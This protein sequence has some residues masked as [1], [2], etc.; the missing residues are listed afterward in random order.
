METEF[1]PVYFN[2]ITKTLIS[3]DKSIEEILYKI[4]N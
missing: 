1:A 3:S 4:D 2:S